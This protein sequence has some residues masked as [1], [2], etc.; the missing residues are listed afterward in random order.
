[1]GPFNEVKIHFIMRKKML[2][3]STNVV[4]TH[5]LEQHHGAVRSLCCS[6]T[7]PSNGVT[8]FY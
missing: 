4:P 6:F 5:A 8:L 2:L 3:L 7:T 1:M